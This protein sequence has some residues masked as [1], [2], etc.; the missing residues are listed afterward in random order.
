[1]RRISAG[2]AVLALVGGGSVAAAAEPSVRYAKGALSAT[3]GGEP[4]ALS[5]SR[6]LGTL[7][8]AADVLPVA[9]ADAIGRHGQKD[10][11]ATA[12]LIVHDPDLVAWVRTEDLIVVTAAT[13]YLAP[14]AKD[15]GKKHEVGVTLAPGAPVEVLERTKTAAHVRYEDRFLRADGWVP[16]AAV[17]RV[18]PEDRANVFDEDPDAPSRLPEKVELLATPAG[19]P[20]VTM[21]RPESLDEKVGK[22]VRQHALVELRWDRVTV[23]GWIASDRLA[24]A[25]DEGGLEGG[26]RGGATGS[27]W[28]K[29]AVAPGTEVLDRPGGTVLGAYV[30]KQNVKVLETKD[31]FRRITLQTDLGR[32]MSVWLPPSPKPAPAPTPR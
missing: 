26:M 6:V 24:P 9:P 30:T 10:G 2:I 27:N 28:D 13:A 22:V 14:T 8:P 20:L 32:S 17:G 12:L 16:L 19:K 3:P 7:R 1:M 21:A 5:E 23:V 18:F 4:L 11:E 15:I 31:G 29:E 25:S